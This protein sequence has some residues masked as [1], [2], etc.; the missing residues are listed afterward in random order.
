MHVTYLFGKPVKPVLSC[1]CIELVTEL[2]TVYNIKHQLSAQ[3]P[4]CMMHYE[5]DRAR[6][7]P[8]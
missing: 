4:L 5:P 7:E 3:M 2:V 1:P 6:E 8:V